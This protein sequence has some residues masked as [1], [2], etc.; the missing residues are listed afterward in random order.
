VSRRFVLLADHVPRAFHEF[1]DS[2][3]N[4]PVRHS[5]PGRSWINQQSIGGATVM[6]GGLLIGLPRAGRV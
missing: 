6:N 4:W 5:L 1:W 2:R 3:Q